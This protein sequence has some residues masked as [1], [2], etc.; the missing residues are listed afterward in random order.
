MLEFIKNQL[1]PDRKF[2]KFQWMDRIL[3][4][5]G[6]QETIWWLHNQGMKIT[7]N[8]LKGTVQGG[9]YNIA[10]WIIDLGIK[11]D[12]DTIDCIIKDNQFDWLMAVIPSVISPECYNSAIKY[13]NTSAM[14]K[15][16]SLNIPLTIEYFPLD[17]AVVNC[18]IKS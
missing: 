13:K 17:V 4:T 11:P 5:W 7:S 10:K 16:V 15:L 2:T 3:G 6:N 8:T 1:L 14:E 9:H 12:S 18:L